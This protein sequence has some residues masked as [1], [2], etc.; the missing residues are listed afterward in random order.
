MPLGKLDQPL[1]LAKR[2]TFN[3]FRHWITAAGC[4]ITGYRRNLPNGYND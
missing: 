3:Y 2:C 4:S 1:L